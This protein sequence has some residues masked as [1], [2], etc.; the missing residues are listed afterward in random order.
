MTETTLPTP[1]PFK[2][3][4]RWIDK[5]I[6][7]AV[8]ALTCV[9]VFDLPAFWPAVSFASDAF[10]GTLPFIIFAVL[11]VAYATA[12]GAE[13][14]LAKA[15]EGAPARMIVMAAIIGGVSPFCSCEVIP[16]IAAAL[17]MGVP[18]AAVMAFWLSS[19]LMDP[20]M[21]LITA[22]GLGVDFALA[23][24]GFAV[25]IGFMG[26]FGVLALSR[27]VLFTDP[28]KPSTTGRT[29]SCCSA[30]PL[31]GAT[32]WAFWKEPARVERFRDTAIENALFLGKWLIVAY[33]FEALMVA[34]IPAELIATLLGGT[35]IGPI[36][37]ASL[38]GAPAYLNG[39][40]AVPL[41]DGLLDQGMAD[42][43]AMSFM[44][45]GGISCIP[46][47]IA[48]FALVR[49]KVF[50]AYLGFAFIGAVLAGIIWGIYIA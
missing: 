46:A 15:F 30:K 47:A 28:L 48:V 24:T 34:Y 43:A 22:G 16:F 6:L 29:G 20:A 23:K 32:V 13:N 49:A 10:V 26:G 35:G 39:F 44:I 3:F 27:S 8:L 50:A 31:G 45:A 18:L 42:G 33:V 19:P 25:L 12:S 9:A 40:A 14:L 2:S 4:W 17:A 36:V 1:N 7:V 38:V 37:I 11:A 21:F 41:I 5:P